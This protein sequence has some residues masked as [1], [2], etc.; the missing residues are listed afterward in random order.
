MDSNS[1]LIACVN[2]NTYNKL[3]TYISSVIDSKIQSNLKL[4]ID[5]L[6]GDNSCNKKE[7]NVSK[8]KDLN[9]H[10]IFNER[11]FGYLGGVVEAL[12]KTKLRPEDY[13][14]FVISNV[15]LRVPITFFQDL[16]NTKFDPNIGWIAPSIISEKEN[17]DRNPKIIARPSKMK[18]KITA[19]M[20]WMPVIHLFY[21]KFVYPGKKR[22]SHKY[23]NKKIYAGHG[24][25]MLFTNSFTKKNVDL[26]YQSFL[27]GEEIFF[28]ELNRISGLDTIYF[29]K[30][31]VHDIDHVSTSKMK[32]S[33]YYKMNFQSIKYIIKRFF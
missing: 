5:I 25:F 18:M 16:F 31:V 28:A 23:L 21:S 8:I 10:H 3:E 14:Y 2:F 13:R 19:F 11:N 20:Y 1:I 33:E 24:S 29:P 6:I 17:R 26:D 30:L 27:F 22:D 15:D 12:S 32:K 9:I 7:L 4:N